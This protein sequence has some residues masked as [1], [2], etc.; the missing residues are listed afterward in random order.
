MQNTIIFSASLT[1]AAI[2]DGLQS[3]PRFH[4]DDIKGILDDDPAKLHKGFYG[5]RVVG[6]FSDI[7]SVIDELGLTHFVIGLADQ[8]HML[9]REYIFDKCKS[10][11]LTPLSSIHTRS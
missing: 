5:Y 9:I 10:L 8:R 3:S 4:E 11:G 1:S 7:Y 6:M 2:L